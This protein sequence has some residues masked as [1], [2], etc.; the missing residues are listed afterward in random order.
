VPQYTIPQC[1][2]LL[3]KV[4]DSDQDKARYQALGLLVHLINQNCLGVE[5][6]EGFSTKQFIEITERDL[7][8]EG[9]DKLIQAVKV[10]SKLAVSKQKVQELHEKAIEAR[11]HID[12]LFD[13][14]RV[15]KEEFK[16]LEESFKVLRE[17]AQANLR[18]K[19]ALNDAEEARLLIDEALKPPEKLKE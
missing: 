10:L 17:F 3:I 5:I 9:E 11:K 4:S 8:T 15:S 14:K 1:P 6:P 13:I 12:I 2:E 7:M 16:R 18:Y 19:D